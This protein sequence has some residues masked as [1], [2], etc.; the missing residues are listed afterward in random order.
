VRSGLLNNYEGSLV[1]GDYHNGP[2]SVLMPFGLWGAIAVAWLLAAGVKVLYDNFR[3]GDVR[4]RLINTALLSF[5]LAE[6]FSVPYCV[7]R[8]EFAVVVFFGNSW[9]QCQP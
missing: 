9:P 6:I 5:F 3:Y 2:L 8:L 7:R 1:A 4:L